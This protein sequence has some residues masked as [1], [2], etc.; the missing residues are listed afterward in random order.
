VTDERYQLSTS[1]AANYERNN[2]RLTFGPW[3]KVL[4]ERSG[5]RP[6]DR[7]LDVACGT[8]IV[9]R[10]V[11]PIVGSAGAAIG[12]DLNEDM[13][14][15]AAK[16]VPAGV[17]LEWCQSDAEHLAFDDEDFDVVFCQ[18]ALQYF[19]DRAAA[20]SEMCR[21]LRPAG[22]AVVAVWRGLDH[23]IIQRTW[24]ECL[25]RHL[26][27]EV[28]AK[29]FSS[30]FSKELDDAA[31]LTALFDT[32]GFSSVDVQPVEQVIPADDAR[33][34]MESAVVRF[35]DQLAAMEPEANK[36]MWTEVMATIEPWV[37]NGRLEA[38]ATINLILAHK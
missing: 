32:A 25:S 28:G 23:N 3:A 37:V 9:A 31:L 18:Q 11:A 27:P 6:G 4:V 30:G 33:D 38:P 5:V 10:T 34:R 26:S 20:V 19:P 29:A 16:H 7:V 1:A 22:V 36:S 2:V 8:G 17:N 24:S 15:E 13:L 35:A 12:T 14:A 21:V